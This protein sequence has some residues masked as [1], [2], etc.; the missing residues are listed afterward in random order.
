M[1]AKNSIKTYISDGFYHIYNRGVE[2]RIIFNNRQDYKVFF[3]YLKLYLCPKKE[4]IGEIK[5]DKNLTEEEIA[6]K[7]IIISGL[8]NFYKRIEL[9]CFNLMPNH[10]H[11]VIRQKDSNDMELFIR[12]LLTKY[13]LYFN[14][15]YD[16]VGPLFQGVY[17]AVNIDREEYLLH[18]SRYIHLNSKEILSK[19]QLLVDYPWSSYPAYLGKINLKWLNKELILSYFKSNSG[20]GHS[21]YQKFVEEYKDSPSE[22]VSFKRTLLT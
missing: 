21:S 14:K 12:S 8:N 9:L 3:N 6:R 18:L 22:G 7:I 5:E 11:L 16:R 20:F 2:K 19:N 13:V 1:P 10:F 17:K 4:L 15:K